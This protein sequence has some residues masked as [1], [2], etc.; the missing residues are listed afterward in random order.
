MKIE[1][2]SRQNIHS[3]LEEIKWYNS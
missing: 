2:H 3:L 1:N